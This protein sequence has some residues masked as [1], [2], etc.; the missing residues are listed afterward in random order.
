M[1]DGTADVEVASRFGRLTLQRQVLVDG[2]TQTHVMPG[3]AVL[4]LHGGIV[5]TRGLQEMACLLAD[6]LPFVTAA[7]LLGWQTHAEGT[8]AHEVLCASTLRTLVREHGAALAQAE[9]AEV[10]RLSALVAGGADLPPRLV[11][12]HTPRRRAGWPAALS[13]AVD[14]A[15]AAAVPSPPPGVR[16]ADWER[17]LTVRRQEQSAAATD[18]R[19]L[20]PCVSP[21]E[22]VAS[23]DEVLTR[24]SRGA[25]SGA[26]SGSCARRVWPRPRGIAT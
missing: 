6:T 5:I 8:Q 13:A 11:P 20:G 1:C 24:R 22:V 14:Q 12:A 21:D 2:A 19:R 9:Q 7:R 10:A 4:P 23:A 16:V 26:N 3:N 25:P 17:V 18:L 15:L